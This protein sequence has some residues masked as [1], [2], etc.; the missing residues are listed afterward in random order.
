MFRAFLFGV[1]VTMIVALVGGYFVLRNGIIPAN[2]T[3]PPRGL[4]HGSQGHR[5][6]QPYVA[7]LRIP[8]LSL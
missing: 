7:R 5:W 2:A 6:T 1:L 4:R 8:I 3:P